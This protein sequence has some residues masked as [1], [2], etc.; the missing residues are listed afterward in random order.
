MK[1]EVKAARHRRL[2]RR[3]DQIVADFRRDWKW[4]QGPMPEEP[5]PSTVGE[6]HL[7]LVDSQPVKTKS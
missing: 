2:Q 3:I 4:P 5:Q 7:K 1:D 6:S